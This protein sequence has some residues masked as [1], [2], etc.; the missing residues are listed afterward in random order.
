MQ[1]DEFVEC[2]SNPQLQ[3]LES[4]IVDDRRDWMLVEAV[5]GK[6]DA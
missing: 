1:F 4:I 5:A 6:P 3:S 2:V